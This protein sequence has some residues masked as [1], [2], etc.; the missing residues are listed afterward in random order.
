MICDLEPSALDGTIHRIGRAPDPWAW[1]D[2]V[3]ARSDGTFGS[4]YDD[5][6]GTYRVLYASAQRLGALVETLARFRPDPAILAVG[7]ESDARDDAFPTMA[8][9]TVPRAWLAKRRMGRA[10]CSGTLADVGHT[11]SL[12]FLRRQLADRV[13][14]H[15]LADL[16]A[17][18]VRLAAPRRFTQEISRQIFECSDP[19]GRRAFAGVVYGSRFG[20]QL[21]NIALFEPA[22]LTRPYQ[23]PL[24]G[25]DP[26]L[27]EALVLLGL[28]L[29]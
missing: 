7:F 8:P 21:A 14:H 11:R 10:R 24:R 9:G 26:D 23:E 13:L 5:P 27:V 17:A 28:R 29:V 22:E 6:R 4:R 12:S 3:Y 19:A 15:G 16:D 25:D 1:P 18:T 2:W 20:D